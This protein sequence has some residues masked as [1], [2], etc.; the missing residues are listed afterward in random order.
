MSFGRKLPRLLR[1]AGLEAVTA[2][3]SFPV[4]HPAGAVLE[5]ATIAHIRE[6]LLAEGEITAAELDDLL[7][8][9]DALD[10]CTAPLIAARGRK[11][12]APGGGAGGLGGRG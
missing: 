11:P 7:S 12:Q 9:L 6:G 3:A 2:E 1:A 10:L 4:T 8:R 5:R